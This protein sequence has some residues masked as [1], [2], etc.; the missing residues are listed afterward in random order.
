MSLS[1]KRT[2]LL[3]SCTNGAG[4][5]DSE[6]LKDDLPNL[7]TGL[8]FTGEETDAGDGGAGDN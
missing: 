8:H 3:V 2:F 6:Y 5:L 4:A 1:E 7:T